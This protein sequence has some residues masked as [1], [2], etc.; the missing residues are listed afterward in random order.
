MRRWSLPREVLPGSEIARW[1]VMEPIEEI[2][3]LQR[4]IIPILNVLDTN[5][6]RLFVRPVEL[7]INGKPRQ[8]VV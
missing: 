3:R 5:E 1:V 8:R 2:L 4:E 6:Y 7:R